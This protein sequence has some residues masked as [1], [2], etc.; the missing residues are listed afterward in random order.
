MV[1]ADQIREA[2][3]ISDPSVL[4]VGQS[5][6]VPLP[7]TCFNGTDN[8]LPATYLSYVVKPVDTL[9]GIAARYLTTITDLMDVNAMGSTAIKDGDILSVPLPGMFISFF[10]L[11]K[12][13]DVCS[14]Y[15]LVE[16]HVIL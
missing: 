2:N 11:N 1:S 3:S 15:V 8:S 14:M 6:V 10:E 12:A 7:C 4:D 13:F 5:L 9:A 16:F